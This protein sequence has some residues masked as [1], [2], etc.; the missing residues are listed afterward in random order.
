MSGEELREALVNLERARDLERLR[1]SEAECLLDALQ[2]FTLSRSREQMFKQLFSVLRQAL[3]FEDAFVLVAREEEGYAVGASTHP[4]F[5]HTLWRPQDLL[6]RVAAGQPT[7]VVDIAQI[8]EWSAQPRPVREGV[9]SALHL[10]LE[11]GETL[12][13]CVHSQPRA[14]GPQH[15]RWARRFT[16]LSA[17]G[18]LT[19]RG[20]EAAESESRA[21]SEFL[22]N[23]S[24]EIRTP[25]NGIIGMTE[26]LFDTALSGEQREYLQMVRT[27][28][29]ALLSVIN[30]ILDFSKIEAGR[31][32]LHPEAFGLRECLADTL[33]TLAVRASEKGLEL[34]YEV[35]PAVPDAL[36][37]DFGRLRQIVVNLVGNAL[38]FTERGEVVLEVVAGPLTEETAR[39]EFAVRDTGIGIP[40]A[41]LKAI[42]D[43]FVQVDG[44][45]TRQYGGTGLGLSIS[46]QLVR[47]MDG[48]ITVESAVGKGTSFHFSVNFQR[49]AGQAPY[50]GAEFPPDTRVLVVDDSATQRRILQDVLTSWGLTAVTVDGAMPALVALE[51]AVDQGAPFNLALV[52]GHMPRVDGF[53]LVEELQKSPRISGTPVVMLTSAGARGDA[54]RCKALGILSYLVKPVRQRDLLCTVRR[55]L[56]LSPPPGALADEAPSP[57]QPAARPL[58]VL[59]A[60]DNLVNQRVARR[61]LEKLGHRV[62]LALNGEEA[63]E[64]LSHTSVD[65]VLM[66]VQMPVMDGLAATAAVRAAEKVKGGRV[67]ILALT[68][69]AMTGDRERCLEAGMDGYLSKPI[70]AR[71]LA[72]ALREVGAATPHVPAAAPAAPHASDAGVFEEREALER[73]GD[74]AASLVEL[75]ELFFLEWKD[76]CAQLRAAIGSQDVGRV[77][78]LAHTVK[79]SISNFSARA[80]Q[81][82]ALRLERLCDARPPPDLAPALDSLVEEVHRFRDAMAAFRGRGLKA[83]GGVAGT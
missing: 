32:E 73:V 74:D 5:A 27:S 17:M 24:H 18:M 19:L 63:V 75:S 71:D 9:Q 77:R 54:D 62:L 49:Q 48:D 6:R 42:F 53:G 2:I 11:G 82:A 28:A 16:P 13:I 31:M 40:P 58:T 60:E 83:A 30:D 61:A 21:K 57:L 44:S 66:D 80:A 39:I 15:I 36:L 20:K 23:M 25:M 64:L 41:K 29:E 10:P 65:V 47:M 14:F 4:R 79:G 76:Q 50:R 46:S 34:A 81:A 12:L 3:P 52:D 1:R 33:S 68:A 78:S 43:P 67:P 22:A 56:G 35:D 55:V 45:S 38:K 8:P 59:L 69:H 7:A 37:G 70:H 51:R 26:L 72:Q